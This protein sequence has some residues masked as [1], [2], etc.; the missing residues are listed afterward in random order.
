M[1][2]TPRILKNSILLFGIIPAHAGNTHNI[3]R[4]EINGKDHPRT[5]GEHGSAARPARCRR[6]SSPHMR[7]TLGDPFH[8]R[9]GVGII[10]AHAGNTQEHGGLLEHGRDHP[11]TCGEHYRHADRRRRHSGSSPHMR[12]TRD[13]ETDLRAF[14]RIIPAHAGNTICVEFPKNSVEDHPRTCGEHILQASQPSN[15]TGSSPH[16]RGTPELSELSVSD[17]GIIPAHAGNTLGLSETEARK[18]DHPRTCGEHQPHAR[19]GGDGRGSSPHMR[20]TPQ[21][22]SC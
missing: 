13:L 2:G 21:S 12:G 9:A 18:R 7:G 16:M 1:R 20:G 8:V 17:T 3:K 5:C 6:G 15:L 4:L 10:P 11:R 19:A 14:I 22:Y